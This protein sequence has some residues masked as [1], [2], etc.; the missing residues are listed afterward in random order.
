[1][2]L[3]HCEQ[4][5]KKNEDSVRYLFKESPFD[6]NM[7]I[8]ENHT[9]GKTTSEMKNCKQAT[10]HILLMD[11]D[12]MILELSLDI[13]ENFGYKADTA[14]E[15]KE[16]VTKYISAKKNDAS[17]D[18][19]IMDLTIPGGLG[20][21]DAVKELLAFDPEAKIIVSSGYSTDPIM[22]NYLDYGFKDRLLKPFKLD[23]LENKLAQ[24]IRYK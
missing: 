6:I 19:V 10:G 11:D 4:P 5:I 22:V 16:A 23:E 14:I 12:E 1:M 9:I 2:K 24:L 3:S 15:G 8:E 20:A 13:I 7:D 18:V 21:K 17:F